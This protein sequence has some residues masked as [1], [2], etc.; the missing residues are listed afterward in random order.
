MANFDP[1]DSG[2]YMG[3]M[4]NFE[5]FATNLESCMD[6]IMATGTFKDP[7]VMNA[8]GA[9]LG[10]QVFASLATVFYEYVGIWN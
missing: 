4:E 10:S 6:A 5:V 9:L 1:L 7:N 8:F 2:L 3:I